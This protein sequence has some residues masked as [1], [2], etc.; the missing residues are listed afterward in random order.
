MSNNKYIKN[1]QTVSQGV[2][3]I[4]IRD[5]TIVSIA[6]AETDMQP[7][8][9][10]NNVIDAAGRLVTPT[11]IEPHTHLDLAGTG[12]YSPEDHSG[13]LDE[14]LAVAA[15][16]DEKRT[17]EEIE[18]NAAGTVRRLVSNG[19]TK[20]RTHT[21][22]SQHGEKSL[23]A[24][25]SIKEEFSHVADI[26]IVAFP[27]R[28]V[29]RNESAL[30][31]VH[32]AVNRG[33]DLIGGIPHAEPTRE[34]GVKQIEIL[35]D[36]A[37]KHALPVDMHI[38]ET[39][40]PNSRYTEV[41]AEKAQQIGVGHRT[42][43]S[44]VTAMHSYPNDY[45]NRLAHLL[46]ESGVTVVTNPL[47]NAVLQGRRDDYPRRRGHTRIDELRDAGVDVGI[48][49]DDIESVFYRYGDCDLLTAA[50]VLC[51]YAHMDRKSNVDDIW[52]MLLEGNRRVFM[53][54][55]YG[56]KEGAPG[57]VVVYQEES[58][59]AALRE[60]SP[61]NTVLR[62]GKVIAKGSSSRCITD[63]DGWEQL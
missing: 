32:E 2:V 6:D 10:D 46:A 63:S 3:D 58:P 11:L 22:I 16:L 38:D 23:S 52:E 53:A 60:R 62:N 47:T 9:A 40:D 48:A 31:R 61:R 36:I 30:N 13:T 49:Q 8:V 5:G 42:T 41:L 7:Q 45:A 19:I 17:V 50:F 15:D 14:S 43:A 59:F 20:I 54:E 55:E 34:T 21:Y 37:D 4:H 29:V 26:Q 25:R 44:H 12:H 1:A 51:H 18:R 56:L 35:L 57:S 24:L 27:V 28:S 33:V 39:D